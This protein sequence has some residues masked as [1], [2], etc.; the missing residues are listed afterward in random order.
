MR[1]GS[2]SL[3]T[4]N[5]HWLSQFKTMNLWCLQLTLF[6]FSMYL[7]LVLS[8]PTPVNTSTHLGLCDPALLNACLSFCLNLRCLTGLCVGTSWILSIYLPL[9]ASECSTLIRNFCSTQIL[10]ALAQ[11]AYEGTDFPLR[12]GKWT[13]Y[14][15]K[16]IRYFLL[17]LTQ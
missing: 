1:I 17:I 15:P 6:S 9:S 12:I 11:D 5:T 14:G 10:A 8:T 7:G 16:S 4:S 2:P 13:G 3:T